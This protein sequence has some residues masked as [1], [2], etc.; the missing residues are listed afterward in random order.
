MNARDP[1]KTGLVAIVIMGV[2][3]AAVLYLSVA[4]F[5]LALRPELDR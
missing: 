4:S 1:F 3:G 2:I 5:G